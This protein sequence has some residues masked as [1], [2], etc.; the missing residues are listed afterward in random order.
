MSCAQRTC[1]N[2]SANMTY[3]DLYKIQ[4]SSLFN[5]VRK[6]SYFWTKS[7]NCSHFFWKL[8]KE[9]RKEKRGIW[10]VVEPSCQIHFPHLNTFKDF[11]YVCL[12]P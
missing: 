3:C 9:K 5:L 6:Y 10:A 8:G 11:R 4:G 7:M 12:I 1:Q 2:S